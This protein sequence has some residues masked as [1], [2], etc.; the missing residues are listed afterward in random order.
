MN[1]I[2]SDSMDGI[3]RALCQR[4]L[5]K[6]HEVSGT[7]ELNGV[8]LK[9]TDI[10]NNVVNIR[11]ISKS[12]LF[13]ELVWY[14]TGRNDVEFISKFAS[15]WSRITD[16]GV[17][18]NSAYGDIIFKRYGFN[19]VEKVI[20]LLKK[21]PESRRAVINFNVP[22]EKVI[23]TKDEICT[24]SL[25]MILRD[26]KLDCI[27]VM[28]SNDIWF[29]L[30]YD[31]VFFTELQ[32]HIARELGVEYGTYTHF[33]GSLH[34]YDRFIPKIEESCTAK[35]RSKITVDGEKLIYFAPMIANEIDKSLNPREDVIELFNQVGIYKEVVV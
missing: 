23:E 22:N 25:Q 2:V 21:D 13:G 10:S 31:V 1:R 17:T 35:V 27:G 19:Q 29:G 6:G 7:R 20:E 5:R 15:L 32:K 30:P 8:V 18:S 3:Y 9:L 34:V 12:Y 33:V 4:L 14:F 26:N 28:R 24:V 11:N 16:D